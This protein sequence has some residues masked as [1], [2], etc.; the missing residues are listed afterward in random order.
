[1]MNADGTAPSRLTSS[2]AREFAPAWSP[3]GT[4]IAFVSDR[5]GNDEI[6]VIN[7]DGTEEKRLTNNRSADQNP[8]WS[9]S[10]AVSPT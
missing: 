3:I 10:G 2:S 1:V 6:Y 8:G 5:N 4:K 7:V 9:R